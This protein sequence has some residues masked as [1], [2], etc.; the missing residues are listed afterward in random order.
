VIDEND[1][2]VRA[3]QAPFDVS[4]GEYQRRIT[5]ADTQFQQDITAIKDKIKERE[6]KAKQ[7]QAGGLPPEVRELLAKP[8]AQQEQ[9]KSAEWD[10]DN[11]LPDDQ[12]STPG[13]SSA[14]APQAAGPA[15]MPPTAPIPEYGTPR[16]QE[17]TAE[18]AWDYGDPLS[19]GAPTPPRPSWPAP[20]SRTPDTEELPVAQ[21]PVP[22]RRQRPARSAEPQDDDY[23]GESWLR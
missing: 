18:P 10:Y 20:A 16:H 17:Q 13:W 2:L 5:D 19:E 12:R 6:E 4:M 3:V 15:S 22:P 9:R 7:E 14:T 23:S 1:P 21:P 11:P 8:A